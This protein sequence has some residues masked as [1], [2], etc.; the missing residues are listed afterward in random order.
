[1]TLKEGQDL[2]GLYAE[3]KPLYER[4]ADI[5]VNCEGLSIREIVEK[6]AKITA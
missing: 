3:R 2:D 4:Y 6:I 1:M 5:T